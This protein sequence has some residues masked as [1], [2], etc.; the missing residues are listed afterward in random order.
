MLI[1]IKENIATFIVIAIVAILLFAAVFKLIKDKRNG[2]SCCGGC[3]GC[4]MKES[5]H[6]KKI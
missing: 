6:K 4:A 1:F 3:D 2:R 5:C